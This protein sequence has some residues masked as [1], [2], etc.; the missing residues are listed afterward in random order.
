MSDK[1]EKLDEFL[2]EEG[3]N[4]EEGTICDMEGNCKPKYIKHDKSIVE[5]VNKKIIIEDGRQ[6]LM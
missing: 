4:P 6:L 2:N 1:L 3:Q 5:R